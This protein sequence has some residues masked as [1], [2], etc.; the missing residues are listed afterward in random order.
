MAVDAL[1]F[2]RG[3]HGFVGGYNV[4]GGFN[5]ALP[6]G[7][8]PV[9]RGTPQWGKEWRYQTASGRDIVVVLDLSRSM[10]AEPKPRQERARAMLLHLCDTVEHVWARG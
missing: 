2:D 9:P 7:Y 4:G 5:S 1:N 8:R 6:I 3:P 10:L